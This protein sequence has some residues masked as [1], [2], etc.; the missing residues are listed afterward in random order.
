MSPMF[1]LH[2]IK[3]WPA[4]FEAILRGVKVYELRQ[5]DRDYRDGDELLIQEWKPRSQSRDDGKYTGRQIRAKVGYV[6]RVDDWFSM[7]EYEPWDKP[8]VFSLLNVR[9]ITNPPVRDSGSGE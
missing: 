7:D 6:T 1:P 5:N 8:V 4:P 2:E 9:P 3:C